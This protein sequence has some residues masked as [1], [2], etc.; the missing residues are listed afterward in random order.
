MSSFLDWLGE[1]PETGEVQANPLQVYDSRTGDTLADK[2]RL[3]QEKQGTYKGFE[4]VKFTKTD[5]ISDFVEAQPAGV[6][7][8]RDGPF[9]YPAK[10]KFALRFE[11]IDPDS[12]N[13]GR[14]LYFFKETPETINE[15][16]A[17]SGEKLRKQVRGVIA[18]AAQLVNA[19][20]S[21]FGDGLDDETWAEWIKLADEVFPQLEDQEIWLQY[22]VSRW[23]ADRDFGKKFPKGSWNISEKPLK[24]AA[25]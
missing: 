12:P 11:F 17:K 2:A 25:E 19:D 20:L 9:E 21:G 6:A 22:Q 4:P 8:G 5:P 13:F 14:A 10:S 16:Y 3:N 18:S 1:E 7:E 24:L 23:H 15:E